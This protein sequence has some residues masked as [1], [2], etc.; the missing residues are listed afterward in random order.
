M[1]V[2]TCAS[3]AST[4]YLDLVLLSLNISCTRH[5]SASVSALKVLARASA[6]VHLLSA[7][8]PLL[9]SSP[10]PIRNRS[11]VRVLDTGVTFQR[12]AVCAFLPGMTIRCALESLGGWPTDWSSGRSWVGRRPGALI[13]FVSGRRRDDLQSR[14]SHSR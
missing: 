3:V 14:P 9:S 4:A 10:P 12:R 1:N 6:N 7:I 13:A 11:S 5:A 8:P 2:G